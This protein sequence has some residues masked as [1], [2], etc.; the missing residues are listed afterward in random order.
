LIDSAF[1][2]SLDF[3][4]KD[5]STIAQLDALYKLF[6]R[7]DYSAELRQ[8]FKLQC[9]ILLNKSKRTCESDFN[10]CCALF[11]ELTQPPQMHLNDSSNNGDITLILRSN[12]RDG[13][14]YQ[15]TLAT[16]ISGLLLRAGGRKGEVCRTLG[17][18][19]QELSFLIKSLPAIKKAVSAAKLQLKKK[20]APD[21]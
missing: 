16:L 17:I 13:A 12:I 6:K 2:K 20:L 21:H 9:E 15:D 3:K 4:V 5:C 7:L 8:I 14:I 11:E 18:T 10:Q 1:L 19:D